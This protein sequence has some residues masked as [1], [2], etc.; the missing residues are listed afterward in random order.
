MIQVEVVILRK[1]L[2]I[3]LSNISIFNKKFAEIEILVSLNLLLKNKNFYFSD[4]FTFTRR[5][6]VFS[7]E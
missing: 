3:N 2:L 4:L 7:L 6:V 5:F 1:K